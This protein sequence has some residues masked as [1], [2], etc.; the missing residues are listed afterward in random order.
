MF[1]AD[2]IMAFV[3]HTLFTTGTVYFFG[4]KK[5]KG[6][7]DATNGRIDDKEGVQGALLRLAVSGLGLNFDIPMKLVPQSKTDLSFDHTQPKTES[8]QLRLI[9]VAHPLCFG[10]ASGVATSLTLYPFDF[11]RGGVLQPGLKRILSAGSTVPY[12]GFLFGMYFSMRDPTDIGS[13]TR[14]AACSA[15]AAVLAEIPFDHAKRQMMGSTRVMVGA[16]LL[17]VPFATIML[18]LYDKAV[19]KYVLKVLENGS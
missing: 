5:K 17:Y 3:Y 1:C 14:W 19:T 16:G 7:R 11:V 18:V 8:R 13:Q 2:Y 12:A 9:N 6:A 4:N 10:I 15:S